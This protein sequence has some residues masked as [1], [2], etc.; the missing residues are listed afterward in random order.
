MSGAA[1]VKIVADLDSRTYDLYII[2]TLIQ[3]LVPFDNLVNLD[4]VRYFTDALNEANFSGQAFDNV[5]LNLV[6][7]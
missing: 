6:S 4:T 1:T 7:G 2:G 5:E 3:T